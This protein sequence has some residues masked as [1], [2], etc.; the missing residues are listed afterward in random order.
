MYY[1]R[2]LFINGAGL[3]LLGMGFVISFLCVLV[4]AMFGMSAVVK[5]LNKSSLKNKKWLKEIC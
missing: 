1:D 5:Y 4:A 2:K 3:M